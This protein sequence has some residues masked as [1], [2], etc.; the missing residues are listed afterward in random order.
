MLCDIDVK[1][2][3]DLLYKD[4][5]VPTLSLCLITKDEEKNISRCINSAKDIVDE[6]VVVDTGSKDRTVEIAESL[7]A[8]VIHTKWEDDYSKARNIA[9]ENAKS[10][11]I[12]FLDADEEIK[13]EDVEKIRPLLND[14]TVE[15]YMFK[16]VNYGGDSVS[17]GL[18]EV[19]YNFRLFRNNGR[20]KYVYP[21]HENLKNIEEN[22]LPIYKNADVTILHYGYL[23]EIRAE[24]NKTERYINM[25]S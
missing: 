10:D 5:E 4:I 11:W 6:I 13:K 14:D 1:K 18:T 22:R 24:K 2:Q 23:S 19:H 21:I 16:I 9:I 7:G 20:L 17:S 3:F 12:L 8:K 25:I 15:A